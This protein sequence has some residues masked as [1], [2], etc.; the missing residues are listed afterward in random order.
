MPIAISRIVP[1]AVLL[2][3]SLAGGAVV[4]VAPNVF[5]VL[6]PHDSRFDDSNV[7]VIE[8]RDAILIVDAPTSRSAIETVITEIRRRSKTPVRYVVNTHW[9]GDHT[10]GNELYRAAFGE[11][12]IFIGHETLKR[13]I[14]ERA[15]KD[16]LDRIARYETMIPV[17]VANLAE[18]KGLSGQDLTAEQQ[19]RQAAAIEQTRAWLADNRDVTFIVPQLTYTDELA[20]ELGGREVRLMH[21]RA[22][23]S[24][25]TVVWVPDSR[26]L[27]TG[28][29]LDDLPYVGHGHPRSW[30]VALEELGELPFDKIVPGHG[31]VFEGTDQ[32]DLLLGFMRALVAHADTAEPAEREFDAAPWREKLA[33]DDAAAQRFFDGVLAEAVARAIEDTP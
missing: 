14:P 1:L 3:A 23:T 12:V 11:S 15:A 32:L 4:D 27:V 28:D 16:V 18:G 13:D 5:A 9:H 26:V 25:D 31:P 29:M 33:G 17:A 2:C 20:L 30:V 19:T 8:G 10:Q 24:G 21:R 6:Q 22:H 7:V